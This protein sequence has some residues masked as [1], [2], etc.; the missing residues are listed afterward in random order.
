DDA[1]DQTA[2]RQREAEPVGVPGPRDRVTLRW[3]WPHGGDRR[4]GGWRR[5]LFDRRW[6]RHGRRWVRL[7]R[8]DR[9]AREAREV[10][11]GLGVEEPLVVGDRVVALAEL[12]GDL[13]HRGEQLRLR[14]EC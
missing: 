8:F 14:V 11:G 2:A 5:R 9:L 7:A 3:R 1:G 12:D 10:G 4:R 13:A 6:W